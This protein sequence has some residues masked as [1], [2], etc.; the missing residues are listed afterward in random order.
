M[1]LLTR[2]ATLALVATTVTFAPH[3]LLAQ[4]PTARAGGPRCPGEGVSS[5][6]VP[7]RGTT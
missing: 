5:P 6:N 1:T 4:K 3:A 7:A 2:L